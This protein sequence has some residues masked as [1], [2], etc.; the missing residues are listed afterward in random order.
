M[1]LIQVKV[2][3]GKPESEARARLGVAVGEL[4]SRFGPM[5]RTCEWSPDRSSVLLTGPGVRLDLKVDSEDVH[6]SG[7]LPILASLL[8]SEKLKQIVASTFK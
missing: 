4:Q 2:K 7:E 3:H 5:V 1:A 8:G 6:V